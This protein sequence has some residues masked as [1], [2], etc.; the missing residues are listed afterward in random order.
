MKEKIIANKKTLKWEKATKKLMFGPIDQT[1]RSPD[2]HSGGREFK[3]RSVHHILFFLFLV[4]FPSYNFEFFVFFHN[5]FFPYFFRFLFYFL[6]H[7]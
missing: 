6:V 4:F 3:S 7:C 5:C 2:L 1:G